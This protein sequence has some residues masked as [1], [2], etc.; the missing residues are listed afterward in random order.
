MQNNKDKAKAVLLELL[1]IRP[2]DEGARKVLDT[3]Q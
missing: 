3:L 2:Q 1:R